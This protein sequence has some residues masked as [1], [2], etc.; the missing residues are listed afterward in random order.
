MYL[1]T[2]TES[3]NPHASS[4]TASEDEDMDIMALNITTIA[5]LV[6]WIDIR[7]PDSLRTFK[8]NIVKS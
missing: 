6:G 4:H 5:D 2:F 1:V 3:I 7:Y 8:W